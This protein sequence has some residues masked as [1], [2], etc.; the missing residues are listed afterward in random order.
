MTKISQKTY[1]GNG[2]KAVVTRGL[3]GK[4]R[5]SVAFFRTADEL[6]ASCVTEYNKLSYAVSMAECHVKYA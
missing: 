2:K 4:N 5:Y 1:S 3:S 6:V